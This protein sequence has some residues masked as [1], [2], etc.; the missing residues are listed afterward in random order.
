MFGDLELK[1]GVISEVGKEGSL[2]S[3]GVFRVVEHKL[4]NQQVV[5]PVVLLI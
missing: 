3:G 5:N 1:S 2:F 4:S